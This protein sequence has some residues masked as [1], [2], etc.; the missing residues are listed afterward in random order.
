[1]LQ[2]LSSPDLTSWR[3]LY[4]LSAPFSHMVNFIDKFTIGTALNQAWVQMML[5]VWALLAWV[6]G[7]P[8]ALLGLVAAGTL[9]MLLFHGVVG[10]SALPVLGLA[11]LLALAL[12]GRI[13]APLPA[14][15]LVAAGVALVLGGIAALPYTRSIS[16]GWDS[17]HTGMAHSYVQLSPIMAWTILTSCGIVTALAWGPARW[18]LRKGHGPGSLLVL[19]TALMAGF[20]LVVN[21]PEDNESKF[22]FEIFFL[23]VPIAA[24]TLEPALAAVR[25]RGGT[26]G[27]LGLGIA[28]FLVP[29][30]LTLY[31]LTVDVESRN[32]PHANLSSTD[33]HFYA[34]LGRATPANAVVVDAD[35]RDYAMVLA[36]RQLYC[37]SPLGPSKAGFPAAEA[38]ERHAVMADLYGPAADLAEDAAKLGRLGRPVFIVYR[39]AD[40][41]RSGDARI[42][43]RAPALFRPVRD[44]GGFVV[45]SLLHEA[46][47]GGSR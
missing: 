47:P 42:L 41:S 32:S 3:V 44:A 7:G 27:T 1:V 33:R 11:L 4:E 14:G 17:G 16:R 36:A 34:W 24:A 25:A 8:R 26:A 28:L 39:L 45:Y 18:L 5:V 6:G 40:Y 2:E 20:A 46:T 23:A 30:G 9:G 13:P 35:F 37:G 10:L 22:A 38:R 21:L 19:I 31:G 15:R 12:R 29:A 43:D